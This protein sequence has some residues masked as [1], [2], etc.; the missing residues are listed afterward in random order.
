MTRTQRCGVLLLLIGSAV[1]LAAVPWVL[2]DD[3]DWIAHTTSEAAGQG[4]E[5]AWLARLGFFGY[6]CGVLWLALARRPRWGRVGTS[7]FVVFAAMMASAAVFS[8]RPWT[9]GTTFDVVEDVLHSVAATA[10]GFAFA[11][12]VVAV[13]LR[14]RRVPVLTR[15]RDLVAILASVAMPTMM[16]LASHQAGLWQR[17]MFAISYL[18]FAAE[19]VDTGPADSSSVS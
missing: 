5:G 8:S 3:Y 10:M 16:L 7:L 1:C 4:V 2:T 9:P 19:T 14:R 18:W 6:G 13:G 15:V 11:F 17:A 12:G